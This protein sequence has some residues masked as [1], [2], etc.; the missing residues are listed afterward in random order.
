MSKCGIGFGFMNFKINRMIK[1]KHKFIEIIFW[2]SGAEFAMPAVKSAY[3]KF[4]IIFLEVVCDWWWNGGEWNASHL[5]K[6]HYKKCYNN[7]T[8][9][10]HLLL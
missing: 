4:L 8:Y 2:A 9:W 5:F 3:L 10:S 6:D 1:G 7:I